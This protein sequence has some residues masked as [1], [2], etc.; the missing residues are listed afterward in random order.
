MQKRHISSN[1]VNPAPSGR[2]SVSMGQIV[3]YASITAMSILFLAFSVA[4]VYLRL[5]N[6]E[7]QFFLPNIFHANTAI[8]LCSSLA[9]MYAMG[10]HKREHER[11][12]FQA[13][14]VCFV[15][16]VMFLVLQMVGWREMT[17]QGMFLKGNQGHSFL[18]LISG[19]HG[20]HVLGG[21]VVM[22]VSIFKSYRR[23][24]DLVAELLFSVDPT[25]TRR[26]GLLSTYWHF[27]DL[28][29]VYLYM[30]FV[31]NALV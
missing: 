7:F 11:Q 31:V 29:W 9:I 13:L 14:S 19:L 30:F 25:R 24:T 2:Q 17:S 21:L 8:I 10:A 20:V 15:L 1:R 12:Y 5:F 28:L 4:F 6:P 27:V 23:Q 16:G 26:L 3:L 18:F 22:A